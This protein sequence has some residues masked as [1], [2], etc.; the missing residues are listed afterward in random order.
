MCCDGMHENET[1]R[2]NRISLFDNILRCSHCTLDLED[3]SKKKKKQKTDTKFPA[4]Q[5]QFLRACLQPSQ[6]ILP[7]C[8]VLQVALQLQALPFQLKQQALRVVHDLLE[9]RHAPQ[10]LRSGHFTASST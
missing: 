1:K 7:A 6:S 3:E 10:E 8:R 2:T 9:L 5:L 4:Y